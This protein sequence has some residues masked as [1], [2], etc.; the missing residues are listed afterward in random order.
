MKYTDPIALAM[1][2]L[3]GLETVIPKLYNHSSTVMSYSSNIT[4]KC[5]VVLSISTAGPGFGQCDSQV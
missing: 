4:Y 3:C 2:D 1:L 5:A